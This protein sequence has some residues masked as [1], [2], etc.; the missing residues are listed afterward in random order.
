M[1]Q[2]TDDF[3]HLIAFKSR[4]VTV[5]PSFL[6]FAKFWFDTHTFR[7]KYRKVD[8]STN[9]FFIKLFRNIGNNARDYI[10]FRNKE[11]HK[12]L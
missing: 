4:F 12:P 10:Y 6:S 5:K 1:R 11:T 7:E 9:W 2:I 8:L 3:V